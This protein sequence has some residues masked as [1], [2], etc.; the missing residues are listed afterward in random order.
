MWGGKKGDYAMEK[1]WYTLCI[2]KCNTFYLPGCDKVAFIKLSLSST[3]CFTSWVSGHGNELN[4]GGGCKLSE[5]LTPLP[6]HVRI[7]IWEVVKPNKKHRTDN[8]SQVMVK[9]S[10]TPDQ[11]SFW[12]NLG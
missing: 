4:V 10:Y 11:P 9:K 5:R 7:I 3:L 12:Q 1:F 2:K 8:E 6:Q